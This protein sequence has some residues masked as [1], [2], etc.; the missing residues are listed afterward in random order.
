MWVFDCVQLVLR[1]STKVSVEGFGDFTTG[2][3][4]RAVNYADGLVAPTEIETV[5]QH[6]LSRLIEIG[7][8]YGMEMT[9]GKKKTTV[10]RTWKQSSP[11]HIMIDKKLPENVEFFNYFGSLISVDARCTR[12]TKSRI[13]MAKASFNRRTLFSPAKWTCI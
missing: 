5:L 8:C 9:V 1:I 3:V 11:V 4:I 2:Q 12:E 7:K 13:G 6:M 10:M